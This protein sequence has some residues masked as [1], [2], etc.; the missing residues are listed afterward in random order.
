MKLFELVLTTLLLAHWMACAYFSFTYLEGYEGVWLPE[1]ELKHAHPVLKY[2]RA[3]YF[4]VI[5]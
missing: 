4:A 3:Q 5:I 2:W 1:P